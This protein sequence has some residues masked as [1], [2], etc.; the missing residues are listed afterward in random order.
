MWFGGK[1]GLTRYDGVNFREFPVNSE[2]SGTLCSEAVA[3]MLLDRENH[4]WV[5]TGNGLC[6]YDPE[7]DVF[8]RFRKAPLGGININYLCQ[9]HDG[10]LWVSAGRG[11]FRMDS[12]HPGEFDPVIR[13]A[14][15]S[16]N[17]T[18]LRY[19]YE[20]SKG[21]MW[22]CCELGLIRLTP[23]SGGYRFDLYRVP[24]DGVTRIW[25]NP[26]TPGSYWIGTV[27]SGVLSFNTGSGVF[28][29]V[30]SAEGENPGLPNNFI[31]SFCAD[32]RG[33]LWIGTGDGLCIYDLATGH[34]RILRHSP[35]DN[36][37]LSQNSVFPIF[38]DAGGSMW[39]GTYYG[40]ANVSYSHPTDFTLYHGDP[41]RSSISNDVVPCF[42]E[43]AR[44]NLWIGTDGG[45]LDYFDRTTG[46]YTLF[47]HNGKDPTSLSANIVK[48]L[49]I[50]RD[51]N[52]WVGT[53][54]GGLE[55]KQGNRFRRILKDTLVTEIQGIL[56][57]RQGRFWVAAEDRI[58]V[59]T[60]KGVE[61]A[62]YSSVPNLTDFPG[63]ENI[64]VLYED[65]RGNIWMGTVGKIFVLK[66]GEDSV[67]RFLPGPDS[68]FSFDVY[69]IFEDHKGT[70]W[71]GF[72][73]GGMVSYDPSTGKTRHYGAQDGLPDN[74]VS[75][76]GEDEYG[77]LWLGT[78]VGLSCLDPKTH[79]IRNFTESDGLPPGGFLYHAFYKDTDGELFFGGYNGFVSFRPGDIELNPNFATPVF[80]SL[81]VFNKPIAVG[82][83]DELL[84]KPM[85][86]EDHLSFA[87]DQDEFTIHFALLNFIKPEKNRYEYKMEGIDRDWIGS[88]I[89]SATYTGLPAGDYTFM[90]K[91]A[92]NDGIW[93]QPATMK[94]TIRPPWWRTWWA[95]G[96]YALA[97]AAV[98]IS[99]MRNLLLR[100][101]MKQE[102][103]LHQAKLRFFTNISHEIRTH[104]AL[105]GGPV[106]KMLLRRRDE[107]DRQQLQY[108]KKNSESLL[109]LVRELMDFR[110]A[111][112]GHLTLQVM[113]SDVVSF[114]KEIVQ[115]L[116]PTAADRNIRLSFVA[117][118]EVINLPFDAE[119]LEKVLFN[120]LT[121]AFKF[122]PNGGAIDVLIEETRSA[123][124]IRV[125]DNGKG[126]APENLSKLFTNYYQEIE[127]G[128]RNTGYGIGL[129]LAKTIVE[130]HKGQLKV[131]SEPGVLTTFTVILPKK[132]LSISST[133][134]EP[135]EGLLERPELFPV[136]EEATGEKKYTVLIVEDNP[137]LRSFL[138][139]ALE[140]R[141][142]MI[143]AP[144]GL[145][146]WDT[147]VEE[148]PDLVIS[149]VMMPGMDG[150]RLCG[151]LKSDP[152]TSHIPTILLTARSSTADQISG[153]EMG[154]DIYLAKPFS[155]HVLRL[156]LRNLLA[157]RETVRRRYVGEIAALAGEAK[158]QTMDDLFMK[159]ALSFIGEKMDDE[160]F[161]VAMLSEHM[162]MSQPILYKKIKALTDMSVNDF[163]KSVRL[164]KAAQLLRE[165]RH[166]VIEVVYMVGYNDR[167]HFAGEFK[168]MFGVTP[169][170]YAKEPRS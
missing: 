58:R 142:N 14:G 162:L 135:R 98:I 102:S 155:I 143:E 101:R 42:V 137:E 23:A 107:E 60:R 85:G 116:E 156:H 12:R 134:P 61:L 73:K 136:G 34:S 117:S 1:F 132:S 121:N 64:Y 2:D 128:V 92:N 69:C 118:A 109:Q 89:P 10:N 99:V 19:I 40:G 115:R 159:K 91:A 147:A 108:I 39:V 104:L 47:K 41:N 124:E 68:L 33:R 105:I 100:E 25:E 160:E 72:S 16:V 7:R 36:S 11:L 88:A 157:G 55:I 9:D 13:V 81:D 59:Y 90:A 164:K 151:K 46:K 62:P 139:S 26:R 148:L 79:L 154:A 152:R 169:G 4:L 166:T 80:T 5:G 52:L 20:D 24:N 106:E 146:G 50:D 76:I 150:F 125:L 71:F 84:R 93:G 165:K 96:F 54:G 53:R 113:K 77:R 29:P 18:D 31:R 43:D 149:D 168:K 120:L 82:A 44:H 8:T 130:L 51:G 127:Y 86:Y 94:I 112:S 74:T 163:I 21:Y 138:R 170:E 145:I 141:Y 67:R 111:E 45:G 57:D 140:D 122:T 110:K 49:L 144:D 32:D 129:A 126:I 6:R 63:N 30:L 28:R 27:N 87:H 83:S 35:G 38:K 3:P 78:D 95:Y 37:S 65:K 114:A 75:A 153:L 123:V 167:K 17:L 48:S 119:Q 131:E 70:F 97:A 161:G 103:A 56:E 66:Q 22:L 133:T 15:D 158:E